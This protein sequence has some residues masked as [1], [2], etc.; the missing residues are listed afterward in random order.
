M[1]DISFT[2][3]IFAST[4]AVSAAY[5]ILM[6][7]LKREVNTNWVKREILIVFLTSVLAT[8]FGLNFFLASGT[9]GLTSLALLLVGLLCAL[10]GVIIHIMKVPDSTPYPAMLVSQ[11]RTLGILMFASLTS[12][13]LLELAVLS[14][15]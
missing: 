1:S 6:S 4:L 11:T 2:I 12:H 8:G 3:Q 5:A 9:V 15:L 13:L 7:I 10:Y 14:K